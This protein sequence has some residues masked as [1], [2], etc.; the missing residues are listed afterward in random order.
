[1]KLDDKTIVLTGA[2]SGIGLAT[3]HALA[4]RA[5]RLILH[6]IEETSP[7]AEGGNV[8]YFQADFSSLRAVTELA[9]RI[10]ATAGRVDVLVNN[11]AR[12]GPELRTMSGDGHELTFQTNYLAAVAL[13]QQLGTP[14]RVVNV[15]SATHLSATLHLDDVDL[16]HHRYAPEIAYAQSKLALVAETCRLAATLKDTGRTAVSVHPGIISTALLHAMFAIR[17]DTTEQ[18]AATLVHVI[19]R[20]NDNG[21]Y[22]DERSPAAPNPIALDPV[23]QQ[24]LRELTQAAIGDR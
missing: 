2:T 7:L 9:E 1:M 22:Y 5:G 15:S 6:G 23:F 20:E 14:D 4:G 24:R 12:P 11:A 18:A 16:T 8:A 21:T 17:G 3:A 13:T 19:T 10:R